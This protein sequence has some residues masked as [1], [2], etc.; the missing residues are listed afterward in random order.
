MSDV[1]LSATTEV[2]GARKQNKPRET[3]AFADHVNR[4]TMRCVWTQPFFIFI[5]AIVG[6]VGDLCIDIK[7]NELFLANVEYSAMIYVLRC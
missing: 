3:F 6:S 7:C 1:P 2:Y 4:D 5:H